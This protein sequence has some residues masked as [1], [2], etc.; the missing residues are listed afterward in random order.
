MDYN[1]N[2]EG[3]TLY[4]PVFHPGAGFVLA[5]RTLPWVTAN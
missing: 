2:I 5:M 1:Q 3:T 4:F